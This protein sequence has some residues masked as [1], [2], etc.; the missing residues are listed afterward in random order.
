MQGALLYVPDICDI[1]RLLIP[2]RAF[3][4][5]SVE[6]NVAG[7]TVFG[8]RLPK[9]HLETAIN[10]DLDSVLKVLMDVGTKC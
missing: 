5:C 6:F 10:G 2:N 7:V 9:A 3:P 1:V 8:R 4:V